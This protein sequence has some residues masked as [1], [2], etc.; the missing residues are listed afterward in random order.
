MAQIPDLNALGARPVPRS[1]RAIAEPQGVGLG[2]RALQQTG[3]TIAKI[4]SE[5]GER[6]AKENAQTAALDFKRKQNDWLIAN[7]YNPDSGLATRRGADANGITRKMLEEFGQ[8]S[9]EW[10]KDLPP[11]AAEAAAALTESA[12]AELARA[13]ASHESREREAYQVGVA[14]ALLESTVQ[15]AAVSATDPAVVQLQVDLSREV[16]QRTGQRLGWSPQDIDAK[17]AKQQAAIHAAVLDNLFAQVGNYETGIAWFEQ[18]QAELGD[19][20]DEYAHKAEQA[21]LTVNVTRHVDRIYGQFGAGPAGLAEARKIKNP[22]ERDRVE[23][24][25]DQQRVRDQREL[26]MRDRIVRESA[27]AKLEGTDPATPLESIFS[28]AEIAALKSQPQ[29]WGNVQS[30]Q[31]TR[32]R[33]LEPDNNPRL[34]GR[35]TQLLIARDWEALEAI[36]LSKHRHELSDEAFKYWSDIIKDPSKRADY[37]DDAVLLRET[38]QTAKLTGEGKAPQREKMRVAFEREVQRVAAERG[39]KLTNQER[40]DI[41]EKL[42]LPMLR[43]G[44]IF[45]QTRAAYLVEGDA[46]YKVPPEQRALIVDAYQQVHGRAPSDDEVLNTYL[47]RE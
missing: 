7:V 27:Y 33:G 8:A 43:E 3:Q 14:D 46:R 42:R 40:R 15:R 28:A 25:L 5:V 39:R 23:T 26:D 35:L 24:Q 18:H 41:L 16:V 32:L 12:R 11:A 22:V 4:G 34:T 37:A 17:Q 19:R 2:A 10:T 30:Y 1:D 9:A 6:L 13:A 29:L 21:A 45:D 31:S 36:D 47:G 38:F 20:R 44:L